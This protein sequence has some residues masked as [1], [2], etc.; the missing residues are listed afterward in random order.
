[1]D[2]LYT[3]NGRPLRVVGQ[4][5]YARSGQP[6]GRIRDNHVYHCDGRYAGTIVGD[7]VAFRSLYAH[8]SASSCSPA[9]RAGSGRANRA[10]SGMMGSEPE[11]AD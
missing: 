4:Y 2:Y 11:F 6:V 1:M 10:G 5:V 3:K 7:R 9:W 8:R